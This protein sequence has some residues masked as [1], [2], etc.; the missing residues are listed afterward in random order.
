[1]SMQPSRAGGGKR[2]KAGVIVVDGGDGS[3]GEIS[4]RLMLSIHR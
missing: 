1:M 2:G 3:P 4:A